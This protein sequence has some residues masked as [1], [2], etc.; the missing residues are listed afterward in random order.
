MPHDLLDT[1]A[2]APDVAG[3]VTAETDIRGLAL[4][5]LR[6]VCARADPPGVAHPLGF[7]CV[8]LHRGAGVG[9][10]LHMWPA[11]GARAGPTTSQVHAHSWDLLSWVVCGCLGNQI[12]AVRDDAE[13]PTHRLFQVR[14]GDAGDELRATDRLVTC[15]PG[16]P[17]WTGAGR[18]YRIPAGAFHATATPPHGHAASIVLA[19][20]RPGT[21]DLSLGGLGLDTHRVRRRNSLP[22]E[23]IDVARAVLDQMLDERPPDVRR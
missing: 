10:C 15:E 20:D 22:G 9:L 4:D 5:V 6:T 19:R 17:E 3:R 18:P 21:A 13:H 1:L 7:V 16:R 11:G 2:A 14:S 12:I 8:P 23:T